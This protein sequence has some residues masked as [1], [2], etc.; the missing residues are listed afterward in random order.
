MRFIRLVFVVLLAV[1]LIGIAL[2]NREVVSLNV[3]PA[4]LG[5]YL[6][7]DW[8][9]TMPLFLLVFLAML[10]GMVLGLIWEW[11]RESHLRAESKRRAHEISKL[12]REVGQI[13]QQHRAPKDDVLAILDNGKPTKAVQPARR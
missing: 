7:I 8:V 4:N 6:G 12:E 3:L 5:A 2:A 10:A 1:A 9:L 11:L 13:R